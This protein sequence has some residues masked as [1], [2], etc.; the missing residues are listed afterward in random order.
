MARGMHGLLAL[1][2]VLLLFAPFQHLH[3]QGAEDGRIGPL[4]HTHTDTNVDRRVPGMP[5]VDI[6]ECHECMLVLNHAARSGGSVFHSWFPKF[7]NL[8][9]API[10]AT[11]TKDEATNKC[12]ERAKKITSGMSFGC[13]KIHRTFGNVSSIDFPTLEADYWPKYQFFSFEYMQRK[14]KM[15]VDGY[16][17]D[18][19]AEW[20]PSNADALIPLFT[21]RTPLLITHVREP[22]SHVQSLM[23]HAYHRYVREIPSR[24]ARG[25]T[26]YDSEHWVDAVLTQKM[27]STK[28]ITYAGLGGLIP[29]TNTLTRLVLD[30]HKEAYSVEEYEHMRSALGGKLYFALMVTDRFQASFCVILFQIHKYRK[31]CVQEIQEFEGR[32]PHKSGPRLLTFTETDDVTIRGRT[33]VDRK[34]FYV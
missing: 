34:V 2:L 15:H 22:V 7:S 25:E 8:W 20:W 29:F 4:S 19:K 32:R 12:L 5:M 18:G 33:R 10:M 13:S 3:A 31:D 11:G 27:K 16:G 23:E 26:I 14:F 17:V 6:N 28:G 24:R 1:V 21:S 9:V 30:Y